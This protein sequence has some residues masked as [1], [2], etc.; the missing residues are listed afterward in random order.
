MAIAVA[1]TESRHVYDPAGHY[2]EA[3]TPDGMP[4]PEYGEVLDAVV[5]NLAGTSESIRRKLEETG[6]LFG[7][8][9]EARPF[10]V[11][12]VPRIIERS[13]WL[14][15]GAA[16]SQRAGALNAFIADV[17]GDGEIIRAGKL[18]ARVISGA[19]HFEP[20]MIGA[21]FAHPPATVIGF[22]IVR[23][24]DGLLR[25]LED[26]LRTPSGIAYAA[27]ARYA[28][29]AWLDDLV[30]SRR[31]P[32]DPAFASLGDALRAAS[33]G[34]SGEGV[35]LLTDGPANS[36]WFE[37][38][39]LAERLGIPAVTPDRLRRRG[40]ALVHDDDNGHA[41]E[42]S[43][44]YRRADEDRLLDERRRPTWIAEALLEP[45]RSG[46]VTVLNGFGAGIADD[47]LAHAY[48]EE[49]IRFYLGQEPLIE[50]VPAFDLGNVEAREQAM[51][52][53]DEL[54]VKPR[55]SYGGEGIVIGSKLDQKGYRRVRRLI[56]KSMDGFIAQEK[57]ALS[58]HP[59][60][61]GG[62]LE[63]RHVDLRVF[64][65]SSGTGATVIPAA[66]TRVALERDSLIVDSTKGGG[67][68]GTW[69]FG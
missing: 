56:A 63:P 16:L 48:V 6:A 47:K 20:A 62:Q 25:V 17:Y 46:A 49:M 42:V 50:S 26:N 53:L 24:A 15:L 2:D 1:R 40:S 64:T 67:A 32:L 13:E 51:D 57:I 28:C 61:I 21:E 44:I 19:E 18:P 66:L 43:V 7:A 41:G 8:G 35:I 65:V 54:V 68:K 69:V 34:A 4:R 59:T 12:P 39:E 31:R 9:E 10:V 55:S 22:D 37:H 11:D 27:A 29:D 3:L 60:A 38:R 36:A 30:G 58:R 23:G 33:A 5:A 45:I 52:R 14:H